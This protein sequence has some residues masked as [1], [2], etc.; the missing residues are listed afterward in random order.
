MKQEI[1]TLIEQAL[2]TLQ[3]QG[4]F[5]KDIPYTIQIERTRDKKFGDFACNIALLLA[6]PLQH[7]P[8]N[9]K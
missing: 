9:S 6:K 5:S 2:Q 7:S 8:H 3:Q 4:V 1:N